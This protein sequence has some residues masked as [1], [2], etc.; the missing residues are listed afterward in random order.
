MLTLDKTESSPIGAGLRLS[1]DVQVNTPSGNAFNY[2]WSVNS[3]HEIVGGGNHNSNYADIW[4]GS[5]QGE[6]IITCTVV[7]T[8]L[9]DS[10]VI[11]GTTLI[12]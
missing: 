11:T 6:V 12:Q 5:S 9:N 3:P 10:D 7:N 4:V 8:C 2:T 1:R